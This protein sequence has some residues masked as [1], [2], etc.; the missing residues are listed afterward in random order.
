LMSM[1][2][3]IAGGV[4]LLFALLAVFGPLVV[5]YDSVST[6]VIDRLLPPGSTLSD[7]SVAL[8][9]TD[10]NGRD[11]FAQFVAGARIS[12]LVAITVVVVGGLVALELGLLAGYYG[13][14]ID[15]FILRNGDMQL[16]LPSI[17]LA[18]MLAAVLGTIL[19]N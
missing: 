10:Q 2:A 16:A 18:I 7:G 6:R 19:P 17:L 11:V 14:W 15:S 12:L 9:G 8:L 5:P 3:K 13:G 1:A 4:L